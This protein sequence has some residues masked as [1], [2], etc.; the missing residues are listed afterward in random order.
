[1]KKISVTPFVCLLFSFFFSATGFAKLRVVATTT[2]IGS[3]ITEI[4][5]NEV[6]LE[7]LAKGT[8][9][10]HAIET[11]PSYMTK[12]NKADLLV[13][14]GLSLEIGWIKNLVQGAR[15][16]KINPGS[17]GFVELGETITPI[18]VP[19][20]EVSRAQGDVHP[21]GNPHFMLDPIR[22]AEA[23]EHLAD[24]LGSLDTE[25]TALYLANSKKFSAEIKA[26]MKTWQTRLGIDT[27]K[28]GLKNRKVITYHKTLNY[29][30][31]RF[32]V[33][34]RGYLEPKPGIPPTVQHILEVLDLMKKEKIN[35][36][37]I[38]NYFD[39]KVG[40]KITTELP[41]AKVF[42]VPVSVDGEPQIKNLFDLYE[43]LVTILEKNS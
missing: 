11:K 25:H 36:V 24:K 42:S 4:A 19:Q 33:Q 34:N 31:A 20:G 2:D 10:P 39:N 37:L 13:S 12:L 23:G 35:L 15:N 43:K 26:K 7:V 40:E 14:N 1:M 16:P 28:A 29:F 9:D 38:E 6:E 30:F 27:A 18:E 32:G 22:A 17:P 21:E 41:T 8:Q 5:G 3:L